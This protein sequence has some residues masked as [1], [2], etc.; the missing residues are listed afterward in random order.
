[1]SKRLQ[2]VMDDAEY[3]DTEAAARREGETVSQWVRRTLRHARQSQPKVAQARKLAA[4]RATR[5]LEFP[6]GDIDQI[7]EETERGYL[8]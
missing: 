4:L 7:L 3:A 1:M 5:G 6:T 2:V 8:S